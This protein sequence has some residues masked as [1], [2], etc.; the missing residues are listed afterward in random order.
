MKK[1]ATLIASLL[2]LAQL[3]VWRNNGRPDCDNGR[4]RRL[5]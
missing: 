3:A 5:N 2:I 4:E 1:K